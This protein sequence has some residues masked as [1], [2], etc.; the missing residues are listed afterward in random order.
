MIESCNMRQTNAYGEPKG[1]S[2]TFKEY[3]AHRAQ[4]Y[5]TEDVDSSGRSKADLETKG[6]STYN[7]RNAGP[8]LATMMRAHIAAEL[9]RNAKAA[10]ASVNEEVVKSLQK[11]AID[12]IQKT[13]S[14]V[15]VSVS[16]G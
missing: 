1:P 12:A 5:M 14:A 16:A 4:T 15:K 2:M 9:E 8:R 13:A 3:L 11:A 6:E 10:L 7:W